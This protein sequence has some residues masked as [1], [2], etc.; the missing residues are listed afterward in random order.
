MDPPELR[1]FGSLIRYAL[2]L[3]SASASQYTSVAALLGE[4]P[5]ADLARELEEQHEGR[6]RLVART[7]QQTLNEMVLEPIIGLNG[8]RYIFD[9]SVVTPASARPKAIAIEEVAALFYTESSVVAKFLLTEA[10]R[11]FAKLADENR[12]NI[13]RI[14]EVFPG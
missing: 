3:E 13:A 8:A 14:R 6:R 7:R 4:G 5:A 1:N 2:E 11:T 9:A 12:R 10:A